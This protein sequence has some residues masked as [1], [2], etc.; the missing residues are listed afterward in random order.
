MSRTIYIV[1]HAWAAEHGDPAWPRDE[2]RPLTD[3]G[4]RR[5]EKMAAALVERGFAPARIATSP[6]VRCRETAE[7]LAEHCRK[8][9]KPKPLAALAPHSDLAASLAWTNDADDDVAWVGHAPDVSHLA[10]RLIGSGSAA[11]RFA[12]G[13][14]AAVE[15]EGRAQE[16]RGELRW[17]VTAA[18]L[19]C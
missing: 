13:A 1:R 14:T 16:A 9:G 17:L 5:F 8:C 7:I 15:F 2:D 4:R 3:E 19:G 6:L 18:I 11:I 12:K 10:A